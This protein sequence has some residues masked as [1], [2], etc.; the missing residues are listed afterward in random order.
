[1][2]QHHIRKMKIIKAKNTIDNKENNIFSQEF[3]T[4]RIQ[5]A[6]RKKDGRMEDFNHADSYTHLPSSK[7]G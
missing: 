4:S 5:T 2:Y 7:L 1:M 3:W 6:R